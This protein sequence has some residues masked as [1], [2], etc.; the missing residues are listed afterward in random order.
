MGSSG[1]DTMIQFSLADITRTV[2]TSWHNDNS[3][4]AYKSATGWDRN[5]YLN[6]WVN[7]ASGYLG[8]AYFPQTSAGSNVDGVVILYESVGGRNNGYGQYDQGRTLVHEVGHYLGLLHPFDYVISPCEGDSAANCATSGDMICDVP[9]LCAILIYRGYPD[10]RGY[11]LFEPGFP[12]KFSIS[13]PGPFVTALG[14]PRR[15][16][17]R[18]FKRREPAFGAIPIPDAVF[19]VIP[20]SR[21]AVAVT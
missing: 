10:H 20:I 7:T 15:Q 17:V 9:P 12:G 16:P 5:K 3:E 14:V 6:I 19:A 13:V 1:F 4:S 21:V 8:Y 11:L 2:N 18:P